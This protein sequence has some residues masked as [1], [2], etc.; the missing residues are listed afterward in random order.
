M[1]SPQTLI[2]VQTTLEIMISQIN[3]QQLNKL[4]NNLKIFMPLLT[5]T[6]KTTLWIKT[7]K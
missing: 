5:N 7:F 3:I 4:H 6:Q 1:N 2:Q